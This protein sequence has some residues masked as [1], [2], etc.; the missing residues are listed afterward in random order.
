MLLRLFTYASFDLY[1]ILW[2]PWAFVAARRFIVNLAI[3]VV[4]FLDVVL[5]FFTGY[6]DDNDTYHAD[7]RSIRQNYLRF[8]KVRVIRVH[9]FVLAF[10]LVLLRVFLLLSP[11]L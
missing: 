10:E 5:M 8:P 2:G 3:D 4:F 1:D 7:F 11:L 6:W 9:R